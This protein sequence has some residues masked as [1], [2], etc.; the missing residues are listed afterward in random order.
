MRGISDS[1]FSHDL[2][3]TT[4]V[5]PKSAVSSQRGG[6]VDCASGFVRSRR[7]REQAP[8]PVTRAVRWRTRFDKPFVASEF[9]R[10]G[11][12]GL[13]LAI[14]ACERLRSGRRDAGRSSL[15]RIG[16]SIRGRVVS[17]PS[18]SNSMGNTIGTGS[19]GPLSA[20]ISGCE[21]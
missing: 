21:G 8:D 20:N 2:A 19:R 16:V 15:R 10:F 7:W 18:F 17:D 3:S 6:F 5:S 1:S 12:R 13:N 14:G 11:P 4:V 9:F